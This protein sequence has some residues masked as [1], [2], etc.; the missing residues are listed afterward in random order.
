W[1]AWYCSCVTFQSIKR[2]FPQCVGKYSPVCQ[3]IFGHRSRSGPNSDDVNQA[4]TLPYTTTFLI[5]MC[6]GRADRRR[7]SRGAMPLL[8][9]LDRQSRPR[10]TIT[11]GDEP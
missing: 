10:T 7:Q 2:V 5:A 1:L 6:Y 4:C 8:I 3:E 9:A 11:S